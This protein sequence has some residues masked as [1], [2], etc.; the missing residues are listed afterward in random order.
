MKTSTN[1]E[2]ETSVKITVNTT[3]ASGLMTLLN[4]FRDLDI[5]DKD[6]FNDFSLSKKE[7]EAIDTL[8]K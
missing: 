5:N 7:E 1:I 3:T 6:F 2:L 4:G 8:S